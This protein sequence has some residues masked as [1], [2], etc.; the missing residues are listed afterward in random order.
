MGTVTSEL[1]QINYATAI[2]YL[3]KATSILRYITIGNELGTEKG[4]I[5]YSI[6]VPLP[7]D[8]GAAEDVVP[9]STPYSGQ[10]PTYQAAT[11]TI[12]KWKRKGYA[13]TDLDLIKLQKKQYSENMVSAINSLVASVITDIL[14]GY[15]QTYMYAGVAGTTPFGS[16]TADAQRAWRLLNEQGNPLEKRAMLLGDVAAEKAIGLPVFQQ[17]NTSGTQE[18]LRE[19][20]IGRAIA[21]DWD[22]ESYLGISFTGGTLSNGTTKAALVNGAVSAGATTMNIDSATLTGTLKVG[23]L[24]SVAGSDQTYVITADK[25]AASN[26]ITGVTFSPAS[27]GFADNAVITFVADHQVAGLAFHK[28]AIAF[29]SVFPDSALFEGGNEIMQMYDPVTGLVLCQEVSRQNKQ[30]LIDYSLM[31][32]SAWIDPKRVVR[33]IG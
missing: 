1:L 20:R 29:V 13:M 4:T 18:T 7:P 15:T 8:L 11:V 3:R 25:T 21:F 2:Q 27:L 22:L 14:S 33:I 23:D 24:F 5:G 10:S 9:G 28:S 19:A 16:S 32:G 30:T 17:A 6:P 26:A 12:S 31:W